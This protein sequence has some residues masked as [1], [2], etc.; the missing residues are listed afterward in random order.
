M[1]E[2]EAEQAVADAL[3]KAG[4]TPLSEM[5]YEIGN[6]AREIEARQVRYLILGWR[7]TPEPE[8]IAEIRR[9]DAAHK[10]LLSCQMKPGEVIGWLKDIIDA[11]KRKANERDGR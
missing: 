1:F 8:A 7:Q 2:D 5:I 11:Q 9:L 6:Q 4:A 3:R 10:L